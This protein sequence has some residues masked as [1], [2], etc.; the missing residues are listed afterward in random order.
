MEFVTRVGEMY[1]LLKRPQMAK[2]QT[3]NKKVQEDP[4]TSQQND[5]TQLVIETEK[6]RKRVLQI[7]AEHTCKIC[8]DHES[9]V[10]FLLCGHICSCKSCGHVLHRCLLCHIQL[11]NI[12]KLLKS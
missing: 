8:L 12:V 5:V 7:Q 1:P 9:D 10:V 3:V 2:P 11:K 4:E 6:L